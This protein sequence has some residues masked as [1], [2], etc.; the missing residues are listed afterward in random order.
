MLSVKT[1]EGYKIPERMFYKYGSSYIGIK[2]I[3]LNMDALNSRILCSNEIGCIETKRLLKYYYNLNIEIINLE[4]DPIVRQQ[5]IEEN[6]VIA[7]E[8]QATEIELLEL[9]KQINTIDY[10][11]N[12]ANTIEAYQSAT[13][14]IIK[15]VGSNPSDYT[16][17]KLDVNFSNNNGVPNPDIAL[18]SSTPN[19][20][21][22]DGEY[23][24]IIK[25]TDIISQ[26]TTWQ[27]VFGTNNVDISFINITEYL[28]FLNKS[29]KQAITSNITQLK[30]IQTQQNYINTKIADRIENLVD[31]PSLINDETD[32]YLK[33]FY[34]VSSIL[35]IIPT[36]PILTTMVNAI[37]T[38]LIALTTASSNT[39]IDNISETN[40][41]VLNTV[42]TS[43]LTTLQV[44]Q[45]ANILPIISSTTSS[46]FEQ[47]YTSSDIHEFKFKYYVTQ[48][49]EPSYIVSE[50]V[51]KDKVFSIQNNLTFE[52][53]ETRE[54]FNEII[55]QEDDNILEFPEFVKLEAGD[56]PWVIA[57]LYSND[58]ILPDL[59]YIYA[60]KHPYIISEREDSYY[61][62]LA[63]T[64]A[65]TEYHEFIISEVIKP[66]IDL[67]EFIK[68]DADTKYIVSEQS[69]N[70]IKLLEFDYVKGDPAYILSQQTDKIYPLQEIVDPIG[71]PAYI[72]S[73]QT[74]KIGNIQE[75]N[76]L[77]IEPHPIIVANLYSPPMELSFNFAKTV[78]HP[79]LA[80]IIPQEE[81]DLL[82]PENILATFNIA[83]VIHQVNK[84]DIL[85]DLGEYNIYGRDTRFPFTIYQEYTDTI[86]NDEVIPPICDIQKPKYNTQSNVVRIIALKVEA[87]ETDPTGSFEIPKPLTSSINNPY[88][89]SKQW[90]QANTVEI[91]DSTTEIGEN[92]YIIFPT[93]LS[94][95]NTLPPP[96]FIWESEKLYITSYMNQLIVYDISEFNNTITT[97]HNS[98]ITQKDSVII[99][100][101]ET[102]KVN[103]LDTYDTLEDPYGYNNTFHKYP[104]T[105]KSEEIL[106]IA[107]T[108]NTTAYNI[109]LINERGYNTVS[110]VEAAN[111][112]ANTNKY[113]ISDKGSNVVT[114]GEDVNNTTVNHY[115]TL[116]YKNSKPVTFNE[117]VNI[118]QSTN[119]LGC[120]IYSNGIFYTNT[121]GD[122]IVVQDEHNGY[123][124]ALKLNEESN[125]ISE[126]TNLV[127][128][129]NNILTDMVTN[130]KVQ[131][132]TYDGVV[133]VKIL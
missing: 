81:K 34:G 20:F 7:S 56:H 72:V 43:L 9:R 45:K 126:Q 100:I 41:S 18:D 61:N 10:K 16:I 6:A 59:E 99:N 113:I 112:T 52:R 123:F 63:N 39:I 106:D 50:Q 67:A 65:E 48:N 2:K 70:V 22:V 38:S 129:N 86:I 118:Y 71:N 84:T 120:I 80:S 66:P 75:Y 29:N 83:D 127:S 32:N 89:I 24:K 55:I 128:T 49:T 35:E 111:N 69:N 42:N 96:T 114:F 90:S 19:I 79:V 78:N 117:N 119:N 87:G 116:T 101:T 23:Y 60:D 33:I 73:E 47:V 5:L 93:N 132:Y 68:T 1:T 131:L 8:I 103:A 58:A 12:V 51:N 76:T 121:T 57:N 3:F 124:Y 25:K 110:V 133:D 11:R 95:I 98:P 27:E 31:N 37:D 4:S 130:K 53:D 46:T 26:T 36:N 115:Y 82:F 125:I 94:D 44:I 97:D 14:K 64:K 102:T 13:D 62:L 21:K 15:A 28:T 30:T 77:S 85:I 92:T 54:A 105:Q 107:E 17:M 109:Y 122:A 91:L 108:I 88:Y 104:I 40:I 74:N